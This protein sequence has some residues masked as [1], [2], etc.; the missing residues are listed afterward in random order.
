MK[1]TV[2]ALDPGIVNAGYSVVS[3]RLINNKLQYKVDETGK[4][5]HTVYDLKQEIVEQ[6]TGYCNEMNRLAKNYGVTHCIAERFQARGFRGHQGEGIGI[7]LGSLIQMLTKEYSTEIRL[8]TAAT[9][10]NAF[11]RMADLKSFYPQVRLEPHE[12]DATLMALF[13]ASS[14]FGIKPFEHIKSKSK[15]RSLIKSIENKTTSKLKRK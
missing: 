11:N 8:V 4:L 13:L 5:K 2:L 10:K 15:Q 9:W 3:A 1:I 12:V 6:T 14:V 7:M